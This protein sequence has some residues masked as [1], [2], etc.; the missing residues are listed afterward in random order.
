[1]TYS[2]QLRRQGL[3]G[4]DKRDVDYHI[5]KVQHQSRMFQSESLRKQFRESLMD[6][7]QTRTIKM[8]I[9]IRSGRANSWL[10]VHLSLSG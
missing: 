1:M 8:F 3:S 2:G 7:V 4:H 9:N 5:L 6:C 10:I